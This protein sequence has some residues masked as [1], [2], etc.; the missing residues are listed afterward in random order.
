MCPTPQYLF[1]QLLRQTSNARPPTLPSPNGRLPIIHD[2]PTPLLT[3]PSKIHR[4]SS[5]S[6]NDPP[7]HLLHISH[8][9]KYSSAL[10]WGHQMLEVLSYH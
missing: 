5:P 7:P 3:S 8:V 4:D 2:S 9:G 1:Q 10:N 6:H